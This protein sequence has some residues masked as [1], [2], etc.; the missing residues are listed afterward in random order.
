[1]ITASNIKGAKQPYHFALEQGLANPESYLAEC[2]ASSE[3]LAME[4]LR[5]AIEDARRREKVLASCALLLAAG[6]SLPPLP[7]ILASHPLIHTAEGEFFR[8]SFRRAC[9]RLKLPLTEVRERDLDDRAAGSLKSEIAGLGK[10]LGPPWT[11]D[12]KSAC[13]AALLALMDGRKPHRA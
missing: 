5:Q 12:Q 2:A 6:R 1:M 13:L 11:T 8:E 7:K 10:T 4:G 9:E 3:G